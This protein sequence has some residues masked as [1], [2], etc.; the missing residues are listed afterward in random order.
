[1]VAANDNSGGSWD[2]LM[3]FAIDASMLDSEWPGIIG[4]GVKNKMCATSR[5][6]WYP[7]GYDQPP[8][9]SKRVLTTWSY[10]NK[11]VISAYPIK[12]SHAGCDINKL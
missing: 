8:A 4:P 7:N 2:D 5:V 12:D 9:Y 1:M 10:N 11:T 6:Y 3:P